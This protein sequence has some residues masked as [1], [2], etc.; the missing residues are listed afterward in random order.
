MV[1]YANLRE[2]R[3]PPVIGEPPGA[4]GLRGRIVFRADKGTKPGM[5]GRTAVNQAER[6][7]I[8][9][10]ARGGVHHPPEHGVGRCHRGKCEEQ[11]AR[12]PRSH[13]PMRENQRGFG[14]AGSG[15]I[16]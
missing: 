14:F 2:Q 11:P 1:P 10:E 15:R 6:R 7:V 4:A 3:T 13:H 12:V 5:K 8:R 9:E 16:L